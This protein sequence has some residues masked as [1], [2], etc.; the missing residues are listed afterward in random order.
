MPVPYLEAD[1]KECQLAVGEVRQRRQKI[2][3]GT[4]L[5][6]KWATGTPYSRGTLGLN[7][8]HLSPLKGKEVGELILQ[9]SSVSEGCYWE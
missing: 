6:S 8:L 5:S 1:L 4:L 2:I 7:S 9:F 3:K